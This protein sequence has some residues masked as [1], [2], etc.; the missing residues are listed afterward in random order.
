MGLTSSFV[1]EM[2]GFVALGWLADRSFGTGRKCL[3]GF[4]VLGVVFSLF[5]LLR[6]LLRM[7]ER[8]R[9]AQHARR[10][11]NSPPAS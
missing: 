1:G 8:E 2:V 6:T 9:E 3:I 10:T 4:G 11:G 7:Q 5:H